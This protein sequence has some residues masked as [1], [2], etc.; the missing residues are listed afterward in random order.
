ML[1]TDTLVPINLIDIRPDA[2]NFDELKALRFSEFITQGHVFESIQVTS[3]PS[4]GRFTLRDGRHRYQAV[5]LLK[6]KFI[7]AS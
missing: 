7:L 3:H 6:L 1:D 2:L 4:T 5:K